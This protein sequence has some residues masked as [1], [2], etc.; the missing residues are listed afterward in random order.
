MIIY[1]DHVLTV[2]VVQLNKFAW[3]F[4]KEMATDEFFFGLLIGSMI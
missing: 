2:D 1:K 3:K 4:I